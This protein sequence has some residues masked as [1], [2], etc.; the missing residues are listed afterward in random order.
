MSDAVI[1]E[2]QNRLGKKVCLTAPTDL[3]GWEKGARYDS[4][5]ALA[6]L[7]PETTADVSAAMA[8]C[9]RAG[10]AVIPQSGN[11]GLVGGGTPGPFGDHVIL[12]LDRMTSQFDLDADNRSLSV[13]AG[14][15]LSMSMTGYQPTIYAFPS[16]SVLTPVSGGWSRRTPAAPVFCDT[17][18]SG[19]I[20]LG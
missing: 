13:S 19:R 2:L 16:T 11:T 20:L 9:F 10:V 5:R 7:R 4:G 8:A 17:A 18:M 6:V 15:R 1:A 12:S 14:V 3:S